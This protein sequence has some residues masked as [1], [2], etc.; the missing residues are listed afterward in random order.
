MLSSDP[1]CDVCV[2]VC[3]CVYLCLC[4]FHLTARSV[5]R[6]QRAVFRIHVNDFHGAAEDLAVFLEQFPEPATNSGMDRCVLT[7]AV[8]G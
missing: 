4:V 8:C 1:F 5:L 3:V 2:C 6:T 7:F